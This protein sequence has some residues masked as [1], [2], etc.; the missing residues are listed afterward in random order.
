M[1]GV[2]PEGLPQAVAVATTVTS[3]T[4]ERENVLLDERRVPL[5]LVTDIS[6]YPRV[7]GSVSLRPRVGP[8]EPEAPTVP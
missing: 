4:P 8:G 5:F 2:A 7:P 1:T 3:K 6:R